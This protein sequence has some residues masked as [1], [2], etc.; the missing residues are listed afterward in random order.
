MTIMPSVD[1]LQKPITLSHSGHDVLTSAGAPVLLG[2]AKQVTVQAAADGASLI[3]GASSVDGQTSMLDVSLG[4][5]SIHTSK[6]NLPSIPLTFVVLTIAACR[7]AFC[8]IRPHI[9]LVDV[10]SVGH[11]RSRHS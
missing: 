8:R 3:L 6:P 10:P 9:P 5:V 11:L 4:K 7:P 1:E 2:L